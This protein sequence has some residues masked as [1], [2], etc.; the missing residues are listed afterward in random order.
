MHKPTG[1]DT[2]TSLLTNSPILLP[3]V[4]VNVTQNQWEEKGWG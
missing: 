2:D 3:P 4:H 1:I